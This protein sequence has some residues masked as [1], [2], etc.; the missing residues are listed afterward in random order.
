VFNLIIFAVGGGVS[1]FFAR[2]TIRPIEDALEAQTRFTADA[3]HELRTPL[4]VMQTE[5]EVGLRDKQLTSIE[6]KKIL[7]SNLEEVTRVSRLVDGLLRLA[8]NGGALENAKRLDIAMVAKSALQNIQKQANA[9]NIQVQL[10]LSSAMVRGD[11]ENL[12]ELA[13]ILL[14]NAIKYS[15][16][17]ASIWL[18]T[19]IDGKNAVLMIADEGEGIKASQLE[20]IFDR[21]YRADTS[22]SKQKVEGFGIGLSIAKQIAEAHGGV[23]EAH[24]KLG[25]GSTFLVKLARY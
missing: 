6:A 24:S 1:Y 9:K 4:A 23:V 17:G 19:Y 22:R 21:F 18:K 10:E 15:P 20:H 25:E 3:S 14:D 13:T 7:T 5:I 12:V 11:K 16:R 2:R 8:R